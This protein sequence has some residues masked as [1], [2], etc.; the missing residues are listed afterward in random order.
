MQHASSPC[1]KPITDTPVWQRIGPWKLAFVLSAALNVVQHWSR[2]GVVDSD[3]EQSRRLATVQAKPVLA[4]EGAEGDCASISCPKLFKASPAIA[5]GSAA[6]RPF[7]TDT[8][9]RLRTPNS[10]LE[11]TQMLYGKQSRLGEPYIGYTNPHQ[12]QRNLQYKWTQVT[13]GILKRAVARIPR[14]V[15]F[16][17]EVGSFTG[18]STTL[19]GD[20]LRRHMPTARHPDPPPLLAID[21][22]LGDLGMTLGRY[23]TEDMARQHGQPTLYHQWLVNVIEANLSRSVLPLMATSFLGARIL[24]YLRLQADMIYLDSAH[25]Q[26]ETFLE[27]AA[28][29]NLLAPRGLILGDDLNWAAIMHDVQLFARTHNAVLESFDGCHTTLMQPNAYRGTLCVWFIQKPA[30]PMEGQLRRSLR[31]PRPLKDGNASRTGS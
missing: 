1:S 18:R 7:L 16:V 10:M 3:A 2:S 29:W 28:Y 17:V 6:Y 15:R 13:D 20:F 5:M 4:N 24:E 25:E 31:P 19:I 27:I 8:R 21:T 9:F 30:I 14:R 11:L 26:R 22:W 12:K 23:L